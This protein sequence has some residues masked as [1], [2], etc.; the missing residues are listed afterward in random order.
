M[1]G[2]WHAMAHGGQALLLHCPLCGRE[3]V[4]LSLQPPALRLAQQQRPRTQIT[5]NQIAARPEEIIRV[6]VY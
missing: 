6:L 1:L 3:G 5:Q 2:A 4:L